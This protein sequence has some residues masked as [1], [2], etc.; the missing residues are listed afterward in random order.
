MDIGEI[1]EPTVTRMKGPR[2]DLATLEDPNV[3]TG[4]YRGSGSH[5]SFSLHLWYLLQCL[6]EIRKLS[7]MACYFLL[8]KVL[9]DN[10]FKYGLL[11]I[12]EIQLFVYLS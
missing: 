2:I 7:K 8:V 1:D 12:E 11:V 3:H 10:S 9:L 5:T 4:N 6:Q